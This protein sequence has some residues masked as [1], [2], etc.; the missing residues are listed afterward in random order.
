MLE[1][2]HYGVNCCHNLFFSPQ[3]GEQIN[4]NCLDWLDFNFCS[5]I[6]DLT[7]IIC[8]GLEQTLYRALG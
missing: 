6:T 7:V 4:V 5:F 8:S 1:V 2:V 3:V